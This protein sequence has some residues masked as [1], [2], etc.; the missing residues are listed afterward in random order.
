MGLTFKKRD[1]FD[2]VLDALGVSGIDMV[3]NDD[4]NDK[5]ENKED[6]FAKF[7]EPKDDENKD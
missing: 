5:N 7:L 3:K 6:P 2:E 4:E 1:D